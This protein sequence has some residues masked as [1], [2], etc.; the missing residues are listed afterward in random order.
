MA[1]I[2]VGAIFG[3]AVTVAIGYAAAT[4]ILSYPGFALPG[5]L[6][7]LRV[8]TICKTVAPSLLCSI[9]MAAGVWIATEIIFFDVSSAA[10]LAIGSITG[11]T[12]YLLIAY[13]FR[14]PAMFE[15]WKALRYSSHQSD[16]TSS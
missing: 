7:G 5:G 15:L 4:A 2:V 16:A 10:T 6:V 9:G 14:V 13:T 3:S 8:I 11:A 1:G 12:V